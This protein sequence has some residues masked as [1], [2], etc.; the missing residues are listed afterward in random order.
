MPHIQHDPELEQLLWWNYDPRTG[1]DGFNLQLND[2]RDTV[3]NSHRPL[4]VF[5]N[6]L[7]DMPHGNP[8]PH[9][10]RLVRICADNDNF[11]RFVAIVPVNM[12]I[13]QTFAKITTKALRIDQHVDVV[14]RQEDA[15][16]IYYDRV[17]VS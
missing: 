14:Y 1:W 12:T 16:N 11:L 2:V 5:F 8:I 6:P 4:V 10:Q 3:L 9:I 7:G 17:Q 15:L 13:A